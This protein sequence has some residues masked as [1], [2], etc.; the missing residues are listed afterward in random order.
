MEKQMVNRA[1]LVGINAYPGQPLRGCINDVNDLAQLL[2]DKCNFQQGDIRFLVEA[3]ATA[4]AIKEALSGWLVQPASSGDR[5]LFH[6]SGHGSILPGHDG[7]VHDVICP[8]DFDFT[9]ERALSDLD[10][11]NIF[12]PLPDNVQFNWVSDSC[13][14]GNLA[15]D[16]AGSLHYRAP[17]F[18]VPPPNIMAQINALRERQVAPRLLSRAMEHLKGA[19]IAGC[20]TDE[21]SADAIFGDRY[22]GAL[23][24]YLLQDLKASAGLEQKLTV[25]VKNVSSLLSAN[26]YSQ[27]P[28]LRGTPAI[29]EKTFLAGL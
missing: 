28:Q 5:L 2:V 20:Q 29:C 27:H 8:V 13:H 11:E 26:G 17:R 7:N 10:F 19:F 15:K 4:A 21:T 24:Y 12:V 1:L 9:E 3:Q 16:F 22:N 23:T 6:F 25:V 18:L 14:S